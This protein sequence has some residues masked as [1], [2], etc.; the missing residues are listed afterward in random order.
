WR[1]GGGCGHRVCGGGRGLGGG[2]GA[3]LERGGIEIGGEDGRRGGGVFR[4]P[5]GGGR[6][7]FCPPLP[8]ASGA[9][10]AAAGA[11]FRLELLPEDPERR[12]PFAL[13]AEL[14]GNVE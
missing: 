5:L 9:E 13:L 6:G 1:G 4:R 2:V 3:D 11:R 10:R 14:F 8:R 7:F 12:L